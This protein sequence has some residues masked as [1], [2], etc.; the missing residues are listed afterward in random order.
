VNQRGIKST[1]VAFSGLISVNNKLRP[2]SI[3]GSLP[4]EHRDTKEDGT[5][6]DMDGTSFSC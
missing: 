2:V 5:R 6:V 4:A 1:G 3:T